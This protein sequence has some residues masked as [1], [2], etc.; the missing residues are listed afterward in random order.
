M[1]SPVLYNVLPCST[2]IPCIIPSSSVSVYCMDVD[3]TTGDLYV[4]GSFTTVVDS[5]GANQTRNG[6]CAFTREGILKTSFNPNVNGTVNGCRFV[7]GTGLYFCGSFSTVG[8]TTRN[9]IALVNTSGALQTFNPGSFNNTLCV[10]VDAAGYVYFGGNY[11]GSV[12]AYCYSSAGVWQ[13]GWAPALNNTVNCI[14]CVGSGTTGLVYAGGLFNSAQGPTGSTITI[15]GLAQIEGVQNS[16]H[17][18]RCTSFNASLTYATMSQLQVLSMCFDS[19]NNTGNLYIAGKFDHVLSTSRPNGLASIN[20][21]TPTLNSFNPGVS[22][23]GYYGT[24]VASN[25]LTGDVYWFTNFATGTFQGESGCSSV[26]VSGSWDAWVNAASPNTGYGVN[27]AV[28]D[29]AGNNGATGGACVWIGG[30]FNQILGGKWY[31]N[32][33]AKLADNSQAGQLLY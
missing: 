27:C 32:N 17:P 7:S 9:G 23:S 18:G 2:G 3:S 10:D 1:T 20:G 26:N 4:G 29:T 21:N 15:Y 8:G 33:L 11:G 13:S 22:G 5:S 28:V 25:Q 24:S 16:T 19:A 31:R 30:C 12:N 6:L 14:R